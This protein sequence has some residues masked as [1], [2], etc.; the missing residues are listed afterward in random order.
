[1]PD[2]DNSVSITRRLLERTEAELRDRRRLLSAR[3]Y[4]HGGPREAMDIIVTLVNA[5]ER[6]RQSIR[7]AT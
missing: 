3:Q 4:G 2:Q 6:L 1:M 7:G 5:R